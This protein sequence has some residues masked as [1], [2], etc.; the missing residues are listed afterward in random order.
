MVCVVRCAQ[1][2]S[3]CVS[4]RCCCRLLPLSMS[5]VGC[6]LLFV[7][8]WLFLVVYAARCAWVVGYCLAR[9]V[10]CVLRVDECLCDR[11][12]WCCL[13]LVLMVAVE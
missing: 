2:V 11:W 4:V 10:R 5:L 8:L 7:A 3:D 6:C 9:A 12:A 1:D 13:L